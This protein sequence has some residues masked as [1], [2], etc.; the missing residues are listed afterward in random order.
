MCYG[1]LFFMMTCGAVCLSLRVSEIIK[2]ET[3]LRFQNDMMC[4]DSMGKSVAVRWFM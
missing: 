3:F 4:C 1:V 2:F